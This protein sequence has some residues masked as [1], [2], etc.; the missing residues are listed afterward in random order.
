MATI[1]N[2]SAVGMDYTQNFNINVSFPIVYVTGVT[3]NK[4]SITLQVGSSDV[5][6]ETVIPA[7][8]TDKRVN[9]NSD[10]T[11]VATVINGV[12]TAIAP[13]NAKMTVTTYDG[14]YSA[15]CDVTVNAR[16]V[17]VADI[18]DVPTTATAGAALTLAGAVIPS[19]ATNKAITWSVVDAGTTGATIMG[20]ILNTTSEGTAVVMA[21]I[22][23]GTAARSNYMKNFNINVTGGGTFIPV[24][25]ITGVPTTAT[26]GTALTLTGTVVPS[27]A[28]NQA[29]IWSIVDAGTTGATIMGDKLNTASEGIAVVR[30]T[31]INGTAVRSNYTKDFNINVSGGGVVVAV[32]NILGVPT[33]VTAGFPMTLAG[34]VIPTDATNQTITWS[35]VDAGTTGAIITGGNIL[36]T[37]TEG[38]AV[39]MATIVN[40][41]A[42]GTDYTQ[43]FN[44]NVSYSIVY[45]TGVTLN[46]A[47]ITLQ[48]GSSDVLTETVTPP[49]A[50]DKRVYWNS[51]NTNVAPV[52]NGVVTAITPGNARITVTTYDGNYTATCDVTVNTRFV[53]VTDITGILTTVTTGTPLTLIGT[54][55]PSNATN[56]TVTWSIADAGK[57]GATING[58]T[59]DTTA[60][61][62]VIVR[63]TITNGLAVGVNYMKEFT[64]NVDGGI[65]FIPV[66]N[67]FGVPTTATDR[68]PVVLTS[69]VAPSNATNTGVIWSVQSAG[70]TGA[71]VDGN[72]LNTSSAGT[73]IVRATIENGTA[74]GTDYTQDFIITVGSSVMFVPVTNI[75]GV[76]TTAITGIPLALTGVVYP[77]NATNTVI[78]WSISYAGGSGASITGINTLNTTSADTVIVTAT[79]LN[80]SAVGTDYV[81]NFTINVGSIVTFIP[82]TNISG[83]AT[84]ITVATPLTLSSTVEPL[85]ATNTGITWSIVNDGTPGAMITGNNETTEAIIIENTLNT[86][87]TGIVAIR[88]TIVNGTTVG[89]DYTQD[90][91]IV[92]DVNNAFVPVTDIIDVLTLASAGVPLPLTGTIIEF[93]STNKI[94]TWS[95]AD[96]KD[97]GATITGG[98]NLNTMSEGDAVVRATI[99]NGLAVG[100]DFTKDFNINVDSGDTF[101]PVADIIN[102]PMTITEGVPLTLTGTI[103]PSD[104]T[105]TDIMWSIADAGTTDAN[106]TGG[107]TLNTVS[108]GTVIIRATILNGAGVGANYTKNFTVTVISNVTFVP[109]TNI[110]G[111]PT[112][113]TAGTP[114]PLTGT[115]A[116]NS[117]NNTDITWSI[118]STGAAGATI[119]DNNTL[120]T[121]AVGTA[122]IRAT[123]VNGSAAGINYTQDFT[124]NVGSSDSFV[125]V[126]EI[127]GVPAAVAA[128]F[129]LT[130]TGDVAP[131]DA[132]NTS[133]LWSIGS[134][135]TTGATI[136]GNTLN[137]TATGTAVVRATIVNGTAVGVDY[138][139]N[140]TINVRDSII[141]VTGVILDKTSLTLQVGSSDV[142]TETV[143]PQDA[144]DKIVRWTSDNTNVA[145]IIDGVVTAI[146]SGN[147]KITV[148]TNDGNYTA[149]CDVTVNARFVP[150][151]DIIGV[152]TT[153]TAGIT[154]TLTGTVEP[155]DATN[156]SIIWSVADAGGTGAT[157]TGDMLNMTSEGTVVVRATI[158]NGT[159]SGNYTQDFHIEVS[160]QDPE[161]CITPEYPSNKTEVSDKT[162]IEP[163]NLEERS[164]RVYLSKRLAEKIAKELLRV[165]EVN[166]Y[167][168]PVFEVS[169]NPNGRLVAIS[170]TIRGSNLLAD[171]PDEVNLIGMIS[172]DTG[173][174]FDYVNSRTGNDGEFTILYYGAIFEGEIIA[175]DN[176]EIIVFVR[177]GDIFDLDRLVNGEI[178]ASIFIASE[179]E[180]EDG[181]R[182]RGG[183]CNAGYGFFILAILGVT[184]FALR[185]K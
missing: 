87:A 52:N 116:P 57:T 140:F 66:T 31:I 40:G 44:I 38:I 158:I 184:T 144:T 99:I 55:T 50:T 119:T 125:P 17:P 67:I 146:A 70:G 132:T 123:I 59:L 183:G 61:G 185:R 142:L 167:I 171:Y 180:D 51:D 130:L 159:A 11:N 23:N 83:I 173:K 110:S 169:V 94:I 93:N 91:N 41:S 81:Q 117:A 161:T 97:T 148:T 134:A 162:G 92:V 147:T 164:S 36:N 121:R 136:I 135:G 98:N 63:A 73:V 12:V 104:A 102:V 47:S 56:K 160:R 69:V 3:L 75:A 54:I 28:T 149:T 68:V 15:T 138:T 152:P 76:S 80:G 120:N 53:P 42:V 170:F 65:V 101:I 107:N 105:N 74:I 16:F 137:T 129:P 163:D 122:V 24:T 182:R 133:I 177:D 155:S 156:K 72:I 139:Q 181:K 95:V 153:A 25:D 128:G 143:M 35:V 172:K 157:L 29:I 6:T 165:D 9:W 118:Q 79:I 108:E 114:L 13:G 18:I 45:V 124:I 20:D 10:N 34:T 109:V 178:I 88:A 179:K 43:N 112:T 46:K 106:I 145:T 168:L 131:S 2:G 19:D 111:V 32:S 39:V 27:D 96:T 21:T 71:T 115:V 90:F 89:T 30:A 113:A 22:I 77:S 48:V 84:T 100:V 78:T 7:D 151:T 60:A 127:T 33:M 37:S 14:N 1:V 86:K 154:L 26:A 8:A 150:V 166:T 58:S 175:D 103:E 126:T 49:N 5:L 64:I 82:V 141:S 4:A 176:Y 62:S 174:L 85:N